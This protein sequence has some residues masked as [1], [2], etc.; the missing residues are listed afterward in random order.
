MCN[1]FWDLN[2]RFISGFRFFLKK[3][4]TEARR[5]RGFPLPSHNLA[6]VISSDTGVTIYFTAVSLS[7]GENISSVRNI[8]VSDRR[9][10]STT[11]TINGLTL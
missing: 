4:R 7:V 8:N 9:R 10:I 6:V 1:A 3:D 11:R 5:L 2:G